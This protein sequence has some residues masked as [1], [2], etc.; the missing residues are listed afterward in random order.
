MHN[1][2]NGSTIKVA[3]SIQDDISSILS[4]HQSQE[5]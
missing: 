2:L 1:V 3:L 5:F 4:E